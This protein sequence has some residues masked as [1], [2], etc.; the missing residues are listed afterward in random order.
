MLDKKREE[1]P[2]D[3]RKALVCWPECGVTGTLIH[4]CGDENST[5][6]LENSLAIFNN[7]KYTHSIQLTYSAPM[8]LPRRNENMCPH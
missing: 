3:P 8:Y 1:E 7:F 6:T 2:T 5:A 4:C